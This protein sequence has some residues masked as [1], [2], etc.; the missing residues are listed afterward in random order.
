MSTSVTLRFV[1][2]AQELTL[3]RTSAYHS[4]LGLQLRRD[5]FV[6]ALRITS[7][8]SRMICESDL[9]TPFISAGRNWGCVGIY[10]AGSC[11]LNHALRNTDGFV[12]MRAYTHTHTHTYT[13]T[14]THTHTHAHIKATMTSLRPHHQHGS[15]RTRSETCLQAVTSRCVRLVHFDSAAIASGTCA[16]RQLE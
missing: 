15:E 12:G 3:R 1:T 8:S 2:C 14:H 5:R 4:R 16:E 6:S 10:R 13:H 11:D 7:A 9:G